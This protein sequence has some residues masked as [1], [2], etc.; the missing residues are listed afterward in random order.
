ERPLLFDMLTQNLAERGMQK[1][2][3]RVIVHCGRAP[4]S[5]YDRVK[6]SFRILWQLIDEMNNEFVFFPRVA[7]GDLLP[8][9]FYVPGI[10]HLST[11]LS[12]EGC[13][14]AYQLITF[15]VLLFYTAVLDQPDISFKV[16]IADKACLVIV[17]HQHPVTGF[18]CC[19]GL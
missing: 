3:R 1:V 12:I 19:V 15:L 7:D 16:I 10:A 11:A 8:A 4:G 5:I 18:L 13:A 6:R 9:S 14:V 17:A 2:C